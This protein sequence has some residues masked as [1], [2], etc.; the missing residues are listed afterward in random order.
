MSRARSLRTPAAEK[1]LVR[2]PLYQQLHE[3]LRELLRSGDFAHGDRF[4]TE[5]Q[6]SERFRVSRPTANKVLA[7]LVSEGVLEFRKGVGTFVRG[8][9][10]E[11]D[12]QSLVSFTRKAKQAGKRPSTKV[13]VFQKVLAESLPP[14]VLASLQLADNDPVFYM[15][16]LRLADG[17]PVIHERRWVPSG[18]CPTLTRRDL[19][20]SIYTFW[21]ESL[22]LAIAGAGQL[23]RAINIRAPESAVLEVRSG[24]AGFLLVATGCLADGRPLWAER[25]TYR[26][27]VYEFHLKRP[28]SGRLVGPA[29]GR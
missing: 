25:T 3:V 11:Y 9:L 15:E 26:G 22:G 4:L 8:A 13:L 5:R 1:S 29:T 21:T 17:A 7:G 19:R 24:T 20:G 6:I 10:L 12:L 23:I 2:E 27:D 18:L 16:R 14:E 28:A